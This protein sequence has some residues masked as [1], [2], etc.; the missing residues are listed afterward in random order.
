MRIVQINAVY[1]FS[2]TGRTTAE[3]HNY[4][5]A[6]NIESHV[7]CTNWSNTNDNIY[8]IGNRLDHKLHALWS[9]ISGRQAWFSITATKKL[10][11]R[12]KSIQP[13]VV[14]LRNLHGN[15]INLPLLLR[16]LADNDIPTIAVM[17][18]CWFFTGHCTHYT[19]NGCY[20]WQN[21]C[22]DCPLI[23]QDNNSLF[24]DTSRNMFRKKQDLFNAIP[25]LG[26]LGVSKWITSEAEKSVVLR[27]AKQYRTIYN[28]IDLQKFYPRDTTALKNK[29]NITDETVILGV[30]QGW[31]ERKGLSHFTTL[32]QRHPELKVVLV[33]SLSDNTKLPSNVI[34]A[35]PT[36]SIDELAQYYSLAHALLVCSI[37]E[38]FGKVS[39]EALAC[40]TPVIANNA[41]ANP[42]IAGSD[43]GFSINNNSDDEIEAAVKEI[44]AIGKPYFSNKCIA[45][46]SSE[47]N[48]ELQAAKYI[49]FANN[50][51]SI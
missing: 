6:H 40:G 26:V 10:I 13:N 47:F 12:L 20:K 36:S 27:N 32:A 42:E 43:C 1:N 41:T 19:A 31:S 14:F 4:C 38:T 33:G 21:E 11:N 50:L 18:D 30:A 8:L 51:C 46:A 9:R 35:G 34:V 29:L 45:R 39:A 2:S 17:H 48:K 23:H 37:Q 16:H 22:F 7:F 15:F 25:R 3:L 5:K 24:F 28:W 44:A 49:D